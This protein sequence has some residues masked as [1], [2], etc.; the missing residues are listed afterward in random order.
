[1]TVLNIGLDKAYKGLLWSGI[2]NEIEIR[3]AGEGQSDH[4]ETLVRELVMRR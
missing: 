3:G 1:M 4:S 2:V